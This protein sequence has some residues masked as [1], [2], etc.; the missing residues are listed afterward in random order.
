MGPELF[1][2]KPSIAIA[3]LAVT[4]P[5]AI[6]SAKAIALLAIALHMQVVL[7]RALVCSTGFE[8]GSSGSCTGSQGEPRHREQAKHLLETDRPW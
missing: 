3:A 5:A 4:V 6:Y 8:E 2:G 7:Q 1:K